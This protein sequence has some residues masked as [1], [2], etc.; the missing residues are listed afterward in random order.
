[1]NVFGRSEGTAQYI[2][3]LGT[4][5]KLSTSCAPQLFIQKERP[6]HFLCKALK[7]PQILWYPLYKKLEKPQIWRY[8]VYKELKKNQ[9]WRYPL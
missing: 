3:H 6:R 1:M 5:K 7:K 4:T 8:P 9:I 2:V